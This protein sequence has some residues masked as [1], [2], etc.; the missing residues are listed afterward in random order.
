MVNEFV[1]FLLY[2][3]LFSLV[4]V[5]ANSRAKILSTFQEQP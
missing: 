2:R 1:L 3:I 4:I 5:L